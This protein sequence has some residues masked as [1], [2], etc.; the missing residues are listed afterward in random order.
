MLAGT[1]TTNRTG[2]SESTGS[3][4]PSLITGGGVS[5]SCAKAHVAQA[6]LPMPDDGT[7]V[8]V[9]ISIRP[10]ARTAESKP[11][12]QL[13]LQ[14]RCRFPPVC[15]GLKLLPHNGQASKGSV[16]ITTPPFVY[17][18]VNERTVLP[19]NGA[20]RGRALPFRR[21]EISRRSHRRYLRSLG[22][23]HRIDPLDS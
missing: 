12:R 22:S 13:R 2:A 3:P 19:A 4:A 20:P 17:S 1:S 7:A 8:S 5:R 18:S 6:P 14:Y 15:R 9:S 16:V 10:L 11:L 23:F 21:G